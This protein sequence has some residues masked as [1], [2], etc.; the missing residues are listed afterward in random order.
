MVFWLGLMELYMTKV[1]RLKVILRKIYKHQDQVTTF[2]NIT[3]ES[4]DVSWLS[5]YEKKTFFLTLSV[6][7]NQTPCL[8][9]R[10]LFELFPI[11]FTL[12]C[13]L[14]NQ[15]SIPNSSF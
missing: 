4:K 1:N 11:L 8:S 5:N 14:L 3:F 9:L 7:K 13:H 10:K 2:Y 12:L 15:A 6:I